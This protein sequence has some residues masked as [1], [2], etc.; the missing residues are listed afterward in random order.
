MSLRFGSAEE[1]G[2]SRDGLLGAYEELLSGVAEGSFTGAVALIARHGVIAGFWAL[3]DRQTEPDEK[4]MT[5]DAVF[6]LASLTKA[7]VTAPVILHLASRGMLGLDDP[8]SSHVAFLEGEEAGERTL[9]ELLTHTG[10]LPASA[11]IGWRRP[12]E[13]RHA[14]LLRALDDLGPQGTVNYSDIGFYLLGLAAEY[15]GQASLGDLF[16][17]IVRMPLGLFG[18]AFWPIDPQERPVVATESVDGR[19]L[20]G[21]VHDGKAR[22]MGGAAGHAG[23]F[24]PAIDVALFAQAVMDGGQGRFGRFLTEEYASALMRPVPGMQDRRTLGWNVWSSREVP[25][26]SAETVGHT[27][28]TGTSFAVDPDADLMTVLLTNRVHPYRRS[29]D[30]LKE[31]RARFH[32]AIGTSVVRED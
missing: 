13:D 24:A 30:L 22:L 6:D 10:G 28:F 19:V 25:G 20:E 1:A 26:W 3:G 23:L 4:A 18:S 27:G 9:R 14:E 5:H 16:H 7:I 2:L 21:V 11:D 17:R 12:A 32:A 15:A 8:I 31:V 29:D